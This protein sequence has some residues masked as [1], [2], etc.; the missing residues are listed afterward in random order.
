VSPLCTHSLVF[1]SRQLEAFFAVRA[2]ALAKEHER[3]LSQ[4]V[5][6]LVHTRDLLVDRPEERAAQPDLPRQLRG[7]SLAIAIGVERRMLWR[8]DEPLKP[9]L[10]TEDSPTRAAFVPEPKDKNTSAHAAGQRFSRRASFSLLPTLSRRT[11]SVEQKEFR[12][13]SAALATLLLNSRRGPS[14]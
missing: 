3:R 1:G 12:H 5:V 6:S 13:V 2:S 10:T 9:N 11:H 8:H 14:D 7:C 4:R